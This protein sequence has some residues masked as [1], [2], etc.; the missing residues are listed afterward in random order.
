MAIQHT[1]HIIPT[2]D[3]MIVDLNGARV[4]SKLDL[5]QDLLQGYHQL[6]LSPQS[7]NVTTFTTHVKLRRYK[8]LS[9]G[10]NSA[11]EIFQNAIQN[12]LEGLEGVQNISDDIIFFRC[13]RQEH[14]QRQ[15]ATFKRLQKTLDC[16]QG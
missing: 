7:I 5:L 2:I 12:T 1:R 13:N 6:E 10:I 9:F 8:R 4:F 11:A 14:D 16:K 3:D 15:E